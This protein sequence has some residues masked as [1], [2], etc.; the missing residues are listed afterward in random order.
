MLQ[1]LNLKWNTHGPFVASVSPG[2]Q[3]SISSQSQ[4]L[5]SATHNILHLRII[6][7]Y[8]YSVGLEEFDQLRF[9][10]VWKVA[11]SQLS[12]KSLSKTVQL[13]TFGN[14]CWMVRT[15]WNLTHVV[16]E[17]DQFLRV[18]IKRFLRESSSH[19]LRSPSIQRRKVE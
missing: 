18:V 6:E 4:S 14:H 2:V 15:H 9:E 12:V 13:S 8:L 19:T 11:V 17:L 16:F 5:V 3:L 7:V 10:R 1:F